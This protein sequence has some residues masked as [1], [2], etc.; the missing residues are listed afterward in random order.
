MLCARPSRVLARVLAACV[1]TSAATAILAGCTF[2]IGFDDVPGATDGSIDSQT[3]INAPDVRVDAPA[4]PDA[5]IG[6]AGAD[7]R[8]AIANPAAC[9]NFSDGKYCGGNQIPWPVA[10]NDDLVTCKGRMVSNVRFCSGLGGCIRMLNGYPDQC[11]ECGT[12]ADG[13]YCGRD[14]GGWETKNFNS[15]VHCQNKA[16]VTVM[17]CGAQ[18]CTSNGAASSCK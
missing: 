4:L 16:A 1:A 5:Q 6:D 11:D 9:A 17:P 3:M 12:K 18:T 2:L 7:V 14:M 15:L 10:N 13:L 8:D